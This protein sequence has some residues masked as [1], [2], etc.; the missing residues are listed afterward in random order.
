MR[1]GTVS[2]PRHDCR[3][4]TA[5]RVD[6]AGAGAGTDIV[7]PGGWSFCS[8]ASS[9]ITTPNDKNIG[10]QHYQ[11]PRSSWGDR[12]WPPS[13]TGTACCLSCSIMVAH[14]NTSQQMK[15]ASSGA[16]GSGDI[17]CR[18][19][20]TASAMARGGSHRWSSA[21]SLAHYMEWLA[22]VS[23]EWLS[24]WG[25][26]AGD[27]RPHPKWNKPGKVLSP[28]WKHQTGLRRQNTTSSSISVG[29]AA[30]GIGRT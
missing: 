24:T 7:E 19:S 26:G 1:R 25:A 5:F 13:Q 2:L 30:G 3:C 15:V 4:V 18:C 9:G 10:R 8:T 12:R 17:R 6:F 20:S 29:S 16:G 14:A 11:P 22:W 27:F 28:N 23:H 21:E